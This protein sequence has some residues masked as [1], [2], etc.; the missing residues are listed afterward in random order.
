MGLGNLVVRVLNGVADGCVEIALDGLEG[1]VGRERL[2][3]DGKVAVS[4]EEVP[5]SLVQKAVVAWT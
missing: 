1:E 4:L 3:G 5:V 2:A